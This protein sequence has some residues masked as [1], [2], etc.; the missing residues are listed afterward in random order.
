[1]VIV[2]ALG[3]KEGVGRMPSR[4]STPIGAWSITLSGCRFDDCGGGIRYSCPLFK[5]A[6]GDLV[7]SR[8]CS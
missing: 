3:G 6:R 7:R 5:G 4:G 8:R 1:V 2:Y